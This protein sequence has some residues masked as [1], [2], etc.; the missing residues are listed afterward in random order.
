MA[1]IAMTAHTPITNGAWETESYVS[2]TA[3]VS[4]ILTGVKALQNVRREKP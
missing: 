2:L 3:S 4:L 1:M